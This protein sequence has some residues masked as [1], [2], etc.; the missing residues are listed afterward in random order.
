M[1][2]IKKV[3]FNGRLMNASGC[4]CT[5][6]DDIN[7]LML[8]QSAAIV[9]KSCTL[10]PREGNIMPRYYEN[11][12]LS[13]NSTGLANMGFEFYQDM[14]S[15]V[16]EITNKPYIMS[17]AGVEK[18]ENLEIIRRLHNNDID[19][20]ELNL[21]CPNLA[22]KPQIAYD[23]DATDELL[24]SVYEI[25]LVAPV[26]LKLPPFFD[27]AQMECM[28]DILREYDVAFLTCINSLGNG[29]ILDQSMKPVIAPRQG[30]G[31]IGGSVVKP[32]GLSNTMKFH[33]FL[34]HI[35]IIGCGGIQTVSDVNQY[36]S[37]G[38]SLV[39]IGTELI[40]KGPGIFKSLSS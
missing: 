1:L 4:Y 25:D 14:A 5:T 34:P 35:P 33:E 23:I 16:K 8:S 40:K 18:D 2:A 26:G 38:A 27:T 22:G 19:L 12:A 10:K 7:A 20:L 11:S 24:R 39:Q 32:F 13:V 3:E 21:S 31:G 28:S 29:L 17:V 36:I 15:A 9:T 37:V 6:R 30:L